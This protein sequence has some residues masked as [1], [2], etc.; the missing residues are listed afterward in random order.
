VEVGGSQARGT[1]QQAR[2][3]L[4]SLKARLLALPGVRGGATES[5]RRAALTAW[6]QAKWLRDRMNLPLTSKHWE[7]YDLIHRSAWRRM[8]RLPN[9]RNP[10]DYNDRIQWLKLFD[11]R[12]EM[13]RLGDKIAVRDYIREKTGDKY[14]TR[15]LQVCETF[16]EIDFDR[17]PAKFVIKANNDSGNVV[18]V[19]DKEKCDKPEA[20]ERMEFSL[21]RVYGWSG[22]EWHYAFMKPKLMVEEF[23]DTGSD[24]PPS[25]YRFHCVNGRVRWIQ[26]DI[27][28][29]PK[30]KEVIVDPQGRPMK[31][32]FSSHKIYSEE[33]TKPAQWEEMTNLAET[34]SAGWKYVRI[35]MFVCRDR[36]YAGEITFTPYAGFYQGEGQN[37]LGKLLDF[38]RTTFEDLVMGKLAKVPRSV[39]R[40]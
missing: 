34:L 16:D 2:G 7:I 24:L 15:L 25:D 30:M 39:S 22:G 18:L 23:L 13:I 4:A 5:L 12:E 6:I 9:L 40:Q 11:Q 37:V 14:L 8:E 10:Q 28:F 38:D 36:I 21:G 31:V 3:G 17:L 29:E 26:N 1:R 27:P 32:H 33:F 19:T 20:R 35:D